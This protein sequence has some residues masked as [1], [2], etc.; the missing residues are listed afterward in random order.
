M[1]GT[2]GV[3]GLAFTACHG[4]YREEGE[5]PQPFLVDIEVDYDFPDADRLPAALDY[6]ELAAA[7]GEV[8]AGPRRRLL[9]TLCREVL[10]AVVRRCPAAR[11]VRVVVRKPGARL[12]VPAEG[13]FARLEWRRGE[14]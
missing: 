5:V 13:S 3:S 2:V 8:L 1:E 9:E 4:A 10:A 14:P 7:A 12:P 11:A 6:T